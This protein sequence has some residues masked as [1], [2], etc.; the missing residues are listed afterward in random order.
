MSDVAAAI[1]FERDDAYLREHYLQWLIFRSSGQ[2]WLTL[3]APFLIAFC[4]WVLVAE[5]EGGSAKMSAVILM[6]IGAY[7]LLLAPVIQYRR[8]RRTVLKGRSKLPDLSLEVRD[9]VLLFGA[10]AGSEL[11]EIKSAVRVWRGSFL[12]FDGLS[13]KHIYLPDRWAAREDVQSLLGDW[14]KSA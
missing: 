9:G 11:V 12:Y 10:D 4:A 5:P 3:A 7:Q 14:A 2:R 8:W 6:A 13:G 1:T